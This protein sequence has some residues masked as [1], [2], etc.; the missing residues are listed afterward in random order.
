MKVRIPIDKHKE[1]EKKYNEICAKS[2]V[3]I[4]SITKPEDGIIPI[5]GFNYKDMEHKF[6]LSVA[7]AAGGVDSA[8]V[9][10]QMN[11]II[12]WWWNRKLPK[13]CRL[14]PYKKKYNDRAVVVED[15]I[16]FMLP[17]AQELCEDE[18]FNF[19]DIY[20]EFYA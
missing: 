4:L 2:M 15:L 6:I 13:D 10:V 12:R 16:N 11:P 1:M 7:R 17:W 20:Y 5:R 14:L 18:D 8:Q 3:N 9:A 19:G